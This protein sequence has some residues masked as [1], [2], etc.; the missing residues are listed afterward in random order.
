MNVAASSAAS[1]YA[2]RIAEAG[3]DM[4]V[5]SVGDSYDNALAEHEMGPL[6]QQRSTARCDRIPNPEQK[7]N[8]FRQQKNELEKAA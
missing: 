4:S 7:R 2:E 5:G 3:I 6:V 8:A 1:R